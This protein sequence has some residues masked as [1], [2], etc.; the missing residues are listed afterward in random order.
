VKFT[1]WDAFDGAGHSVSWCGD[2]NGDGYDDLFLG[3]PL[4]DIG[5]LDAGAAY[6]LNGEGL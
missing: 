1:G 2:P 4:A 5:G 3:G 6:I